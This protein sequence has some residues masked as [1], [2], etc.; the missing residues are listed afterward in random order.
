MAEL[1]RADVCLVKI[2]VCKAVY[3]DYKPRI[4][5]KTLLEFLSVDLKKQKQDTDRLSDIL[6]QVIGE[7]SYAIE[8]MERKRKAKNAP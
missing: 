2:E 3:K 6:L 7:A 8:F 5:M 4:D 1:I